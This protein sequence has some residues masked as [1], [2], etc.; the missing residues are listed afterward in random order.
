MC[1]TGI[2][3]FLG[4]LLLAAGLSSLPASADVASAVPAALAQPGRGPEATSGAIRGAVADV[5]KARRNRPLWVDRPGRADA[6]RALLKAAA[7]DGMDAGPYLAQVEARWQAR[8]DQALAALDVALTRSLAAYANDLWYGRP[9]AKV[10]DES[11]TRRHERLNLSKF[12]A[13][14]A[15]AD[16]PALAPLVDGL[17]PPHPQYAR[18]RAALAKLD[19]AAEPAEKAIADGPI[20]RPG[21][22]DPRVGPVRERI[23]AEGEWSEAEEVAF[24]TPNYGEGRRL[25]PLRRGPDAGRAAIPAPAGIAR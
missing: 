20:L 6:V 8:G 13:D 2:Q 19:T 17:R 5:Y 16:T 11:L 21:V 24:A 10:V 12:L 15:Q 23:E 18:L 1:L 25:E 9:D 4:G 22:R 14:A 3:R 7:T